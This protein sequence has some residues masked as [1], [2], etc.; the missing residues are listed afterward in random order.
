VKVIPLPADENYARYGEERRSEN[1]DGRRKIAKTPRLGEREDEARARKT[2]RF[3]CSERILMFFVG[4]AVFDPHAGRKVQSGD[5]ACTAGC[6]RR[7]RS[8]RRPV[9]EMLRAGFRGEISGSA[10]CARLVRRS[11]GSRTRAGFALVQGRC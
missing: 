1:G 9:T 8:S 4:A 5:A 11:R 6:R 10:A 7:G 3:Q 2:T